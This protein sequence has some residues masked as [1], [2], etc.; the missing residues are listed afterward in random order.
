[1]FKKTPFSHYEESKTKGS[2]NVVKQ[3][4]FFSSCDEYLSPLI[5][6][7][8]HLIM[9]SLYVSSYHDNITLRPVEA[10]LWINSLYNFLKLLPFLFQYASLYSPPV[11]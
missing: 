8:V 6:L 5:M 2:T 9:T 1:M 11:A 3:Y 7:H 10:V 4:S